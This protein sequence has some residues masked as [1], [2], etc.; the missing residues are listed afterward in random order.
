MDI[1]DFNW[2][3]N[4]LHFDS[5]VELLKSLS[6]LE[7][8]LI[9]TMKRLQL[10]SVFQCNFEQIF[11]EYN[12]FSSKHLAELNVPRAVCLKA[13]ERII[14]LE[15]VKLVDTR[16][17]STPKEFRMA[18]LMVFPQQI[19]QVLNS[20]DECPAALQKWGTSYVE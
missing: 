18:K 20:Y 4:S 11:H 2:A 1:K 12:E 13:F 10:Q 19:T 9:V 16:G 7:L 6:V 5:K 3:N 14:E 8:G 15:L 17:I